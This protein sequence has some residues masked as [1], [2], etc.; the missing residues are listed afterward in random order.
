[1]LA[2]LL[3]GRASTAY[4]SQAECDVAKLRIEFSRARSRITADLR[5]VFEDLET[6]RELARAGAGRSRS[7]AR[8]ELWM[9]LAL[10]EEGKMLL[11][12]VE[13]AR[14]A[15]NEKWQI[16]Y[17]VLH[18]VEWARFALLLAPRQVADNTEQTPLS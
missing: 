7:F 6:R 10:F 14:A 16:Y 15:E 18:D 13:A 17:Q 9:D 5:H 11:G 1:M 2:P 12:R 4:A 8:R 3:A